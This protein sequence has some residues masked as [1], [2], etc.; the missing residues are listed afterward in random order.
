[1]TQKRI[2]E[3]AKIG[4]HTILEDLI[5]ASLKQEDKHFLQEEKRLMFRE[6]DEIRKML[7]E[8]EENP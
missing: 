2:L 7:L 1:M 3:L 5:K 8:E 6:Y 4:A